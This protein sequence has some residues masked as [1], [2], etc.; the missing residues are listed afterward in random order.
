MRARTGLTVGIAALAVGATGG[1]ALAGGSADAV[2]GVLSGANEL[3]Q[4]GEAGAGDR[5][6]RGTATAVIDGRRL[7]FGITVR[8]IDQPV[9]AHIHRGRR[10]EN[11]PVVVPLR[12]PGSG[13]PGATSGCVTVRRALARQMLRN[14]QRFY[15][16]VHTKRYPAGAVRGQ[17]F[18]RRG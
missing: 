5:D 10:T 16:N 3:T 4:E 18:V 13:D 2:F 9:A 17:L 11:G 6:G 1:S 12:A 15:W 7:C 8:D 14:P